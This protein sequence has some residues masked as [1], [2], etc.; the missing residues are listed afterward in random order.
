MLD[1]LGR[2]GAARDQPLADEGA[3]A[4]ALRGPLVVDAAD[5]DRHRRRGADEHGVR[6]SVVA[7]L[8]VVVRVRSFVVGVGHSAPRLEERGTPRCYLTV[9]PPTSFRTTFGGAAASKFGPRAAL[10]ACLDVCRLEGARRA[11]AS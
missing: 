2:V 1:G 8:G 9:S 11:A 7:V 10:S 3:E 5:G 6:W 4:G